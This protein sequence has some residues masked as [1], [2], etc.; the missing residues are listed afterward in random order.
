M[1]FENN[2]NKQLSAFLRVPRRAW[3]AHITLT[4]D[5]AFFNSEY[6]YHQFNRS[7]GFVDGFYVRDYSGYGAGYGD[8]NTSKFSV[9]QNFPLPQPVLGQNIDSVCRA[10]TGV[11]CCIPVCS[12][13]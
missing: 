12:A 11:S 3:R 8:Y 13:K 2:N 4:A 6:N 10:S 1:A 7:N 9:P 5:Q